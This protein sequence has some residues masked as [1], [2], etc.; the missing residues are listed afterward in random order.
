M[1][2]LVSSD[3]PPIAGHHLLKPNLRG[4]HDH[5]AGHLLLIW[6]LVSMLSSSTARRRCGHLLPASFV[7]EK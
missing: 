5:T 6:A 7:D 2:E 1:G 4:F 3:S